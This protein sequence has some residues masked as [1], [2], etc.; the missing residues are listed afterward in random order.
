MNG[1]PV[2]FAA[3]T[4]EN[5]NTGQEWAGQVI[6]SDGTLTVTTDGTAVVEVAGIAAVWQENS[7]RWY[8]QAGDV[9]YRIQR[10]GG[11]GCK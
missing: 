5:T 9:M 7:R 3:G 4:V 8:A 1:L 10:A 11:C 6:V 2:A